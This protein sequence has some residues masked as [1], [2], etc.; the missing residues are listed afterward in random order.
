MSETEVIQTP[1]KGKLYAAD[2]SFNETPDVPTASSTPKA[3][4]KP[5]KPRVPRAATPTTPT[6]KAAKKTVVS[7]KKKIVEA[8]ETDPTPMESD[9]Q[10]GLDSEEEEAQSSPSKRTTANVD[11][12]QLIAA[13]KDAV[14]PPPPK[15]RQRKQQNPK[16][17][18]PTHLVRKPALT[19][20]DLLAVLEERDARKVE[21]K[22]Q[23]VYPSKYVRLLIDLRL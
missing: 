3:P 21:L 15:K 20:D 13:V 11:V 2:I 16:K 8:P 22:R 9:T 19:R 6:P 10:S 18:V 17:L 5:R 1:Q 4:K 14:A 23:K 12:A 7:K